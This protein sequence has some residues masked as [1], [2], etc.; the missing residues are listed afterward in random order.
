MNLYSAFFETTE[1]SSKLLRAKTVMEQFHMGQ[2]RN[3]GQPYWLHPWQ[4]VVVLQQ[5]GCSDPK[6]L[7]AAC[8]HDVLEMI[9]QPERRQLAAAY[10][11]SVS[12][13][14]DEFLEQVKKTYEGLFHEPYPEH[15]NRPK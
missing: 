9:R 15:L 3:N 13:N 5:N 11:A 10:I 14:K 1:L 7:L 4:V 2:S 12:S 8:F 6:T